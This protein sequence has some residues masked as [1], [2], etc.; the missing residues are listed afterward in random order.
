VILTLITKRD[1]PNKRSFAPLVNL[2]TLVERLQKA[3]I[4]QD[5]IDTKLDAM[6]KQLV[7]NIVYLPSCDTIPE[8]IIFLDDVY[9]VST[10]E[11]RQSLESSNKILT[12]SQ[13][14]FYILLF[15]LSIHFCRFHEDVARYD[16]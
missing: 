4:P 14:G 16:N 9:Q 10:E 6:K 8:S 15:K 11:L 2:A 3:G 13:V 5:K 12:L 7:T 1:F